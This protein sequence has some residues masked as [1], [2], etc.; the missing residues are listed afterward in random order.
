MFVIVRAKNYEKNVWRMHVRVRSIMTMLSVTVWLTLG[1]VLGCGAAVSTGL[2]DEFNPAIITEWPVPWEQT[3]P[4]DPYV[5]L[6]NR[7]WFVG[8]RGDYVAVL[9]PQKG[10]FQKYPLVSGTGPHNL[11]VDDQ[12]F[13]WYAGNKASHI[14]KLNPETGNIVKYAMPNPDAA[15]P[16]TLVFGKPRKIWFTVQQGNFIGQLSMSSGSVLLT[17]LLTQ[18]ARPY[19][20]VI[21]DKTQLPW[22]TEFGTNK[23]GTIDPVTKFVREISLPRSE[24][25]PRRL[26]LTSDGAVWYVDYA[27]GYV[28]RYNRTTTKVKEWRAPGGEDSRP[29]GMTVDDQER[30]WFVETGSFPN[31]L[32]GFDTKTEQFISMTHIKSGGGTVRHM[33]YHQPTQTIWFGTDANTLA[34][35]TLP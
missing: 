30:V 33:V 20:I 16:H 4:R 14:G 21:D 25:R 26:A 8:Q 27:E 3:R 17:P 34:R 9:D 22:F 29:Y 24:A 7:V 18:H 1:I 15:D 31:R 6:D 5:A 12:G 2:Q 10:K 32:V 23:L 11:I 35:V 19:G 13:V 28:G